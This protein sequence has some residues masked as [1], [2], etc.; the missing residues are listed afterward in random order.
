[1]KC[2]KC[3]LYLFV[4]LLL[5]FESQVFCNSSKINFQLSPEIG[6]LNGTI[7]ENVWYAD[8]SKNNNIT[9]KPTSRMSR[10]DWQFDNSLFIGMNSNLIINDKLIFGF[11]FKNA[12]SH[13]CGMMEDYDW[14]NPITDAWQN[15]PKNELTNYSI[16]TNSLNY[17]RLF[18]F[19]IGWKFF[20]NEYKSISITPF[21]GIQIQK[22]SFDG[23][24]G[25]GT[26]KKYNWAKQYFDNEKVISYSQSYAAPELC[27]NFDF[28][29]FQY[30]E[31]LLDVST[32]WIPDLNCID[33]HHHG[34]ERFY[35]DR[36]KNAWN[37]NT[38]LTVLFKI[39]KNNK[40]GIKGGISYIPDAYGL[41]YSSTTSTIP[42]SSTLGGTSRFLYTYSFIYTFYF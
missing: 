32:I 38:E 22:N 13:K 39:T 3:F 34:N 42:D 18:D 27:L 26:Y 1:M 16:H 20:L 11:Q 9:Y 40:F 30:F 33:I 5:L 24:N 41:T 12:I 10:L 36:I 37:F 23:L 17:F 15:D 7:V 29:Y 4:F 35:N 19:L 6:F 2:K 8:I 21:F 31:F 28:D 14:L 25:W